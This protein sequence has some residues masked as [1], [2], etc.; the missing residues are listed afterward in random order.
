MLSYN[1]FLY[2]DIRD[3]GENKSVEYINELYK[4]LSDLKI[5]L[6]VIF[7]N[8]TFTKKLAYNYNNEPLPL[9]EPLCHYYY[10]E[11]RYI[12]NTIPLVSNLQ[13]FLVES[14]LDRYNI[15]S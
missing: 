12:I 1:C 13:E 15:F 5:N 6:K 10:Q 8:I 7:E 3:A 11:K 4:L 2:Y 9:K 14:K